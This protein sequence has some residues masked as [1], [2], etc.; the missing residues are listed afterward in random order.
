[1]FCIG[2]LYL[3]SQWII[4]AFQDSNRVLSRSSLFFSQETWKDRKI[5]LKM[6]THTCVLL[7]FKLESFSEMKVKNEQVKYKSSASHSI[8]WILWWR[9]FLVSAAPLFFWVALILYDPFSVALFLLI[10]PF[11]LADLELFSV[12]SP[13]YGIS[14]P[15]ADSLLNVT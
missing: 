3:V 4:I 5:N 6:H 14:S 15:S 10:C 11:L 8:D 9:Y 1:M 13:G 7:A 2:G 12:E